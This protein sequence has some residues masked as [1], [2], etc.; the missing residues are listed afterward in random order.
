MQW[1]QVLVLLFAPQYLDADQDNMINF[2]EFVSVLGV[3]CRG[4]PTQRL[5]LLYLLHLPP[6][7]L[8][9][10]PLDDM[11][12]SPQS[13]EKMR[14][15]KKWEK[16]RNM[17]VFLQGNVL[18]VALNLP[19]IIA[20]MLEFTTCF[21]RLFRH[22]SSCLQTIYEK[23][24]CN[25]MSHPSLWQTFGFIHENENFEHD[26][27]EMLAV[28]LVS[29]PFLETTYSAAFVHFCFGWLFR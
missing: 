11:L 14:K 25:Y 18:S 24:L 9:S 2:K 26:S 6:A 10:D 1:D 20:L 7:L 3:L 27:F 22:T 28:R 23:E 12:G 19:V 5:R 8:P 29:V 13:G 4:N 17:D 16:E 21:K 15:Q